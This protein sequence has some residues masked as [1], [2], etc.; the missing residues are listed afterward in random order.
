MD[1]S[2]LAAKHTTDLL[3]VGRDAPA[4]WGI[5]PDAAAFTHDAAR[6]PNDQASRPTIW[7]RLCAA[8]G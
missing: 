8:L 1:A 4:V 5:A 6:Y 2:D 3:F 7:L